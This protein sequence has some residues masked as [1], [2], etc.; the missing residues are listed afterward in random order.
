M[1]VPEGPQELNLSH[2][3]TGLG[4]A[5]VGW[6]KGRKSHAEFVLL[7][8][9]VAEPGHGHRVASGVAS[10]FVSGQVLQLQMGL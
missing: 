9:L 6:M 4:N 3:K 8:S 10:A 7:W 2:I 1:D 5:K